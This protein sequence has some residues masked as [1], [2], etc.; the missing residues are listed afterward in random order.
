MLYAINEVLKWNAIRL[1]RKLSDILITLIMFS[2]DA[3]FLFTGIIGLHVNNG[4]D[5]NMSD[6]IFKVVSLIGL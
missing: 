5:G 3:T 4:E 1:T 2:V 6:P